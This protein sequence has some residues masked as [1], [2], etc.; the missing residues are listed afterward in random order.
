M[1]S[2]YSDALLAV[3]T[4]RLLCAAAVLVL[5]PYRNCFTCVSGFYWKLLWNL[6]L[7]MEFINRALREICSTTP[8][9]IYF[10][11]RSVTLVFWLIMG[12]TNKQK[13]AVFVFLY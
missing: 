4:Y 13:D 2:L 5:R 9:E 11:S 8:R 12:I 7:V 3:I 1:M 6:D 10:I